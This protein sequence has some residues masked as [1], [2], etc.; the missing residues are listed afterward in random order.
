M[1]KR[2][3]IKNISLAGM[4]VTSLS[5]PLTLN[6]TGHLKSAGASYNEGDFWLRIREDYILK[7]EYINLENGYYNIIPQPTLKKYLEHIAHVNKEGAFYMR[8][9]Q[10]ENKAR[11]NARLA[12]FV[13]CA[14]TELILTRNTTESLDLI[15]SGYPWQEGDEAIMAHQDYGAML[16]MFKQVSKRAGMVNKLV[17]I[18][19]DPISDEELVALYE[20]QITS[21]TKLLMICHMVNITGH[22][23]PVCKICD[24]AHTH[25]VEVMVDGAHCI[26]HINVNI[27]ELHCDYYGSSLHKWVAAPLGVGMLYI[28]KNKISK[29]WPLFAE[30]IT[31]Q[32]N[33]LR[34]NH[35]GT[36][37]VHTHLAIAD[38]LDY[39]ELI[40]IERKEERLRHLQRYW[41]EQLR[42]VESIKIFTPTQVHRSC[43]IANV[44]VIGIPATELAKIL[45]EEYSVFTVGIDNAGVNGCRITPNVY[46][47]TVELDHFVASMKSIA[48]G[49]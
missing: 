48:A 29:L 34:L 27:E 16:N 26:G 46:T 42:E 3:F 2:D 35:T 22:I 43:A 47:T 8:G 31:E 36:H 10:E 11:I 9:V 6:A 40:G 17:D 41:S 12:K 14:E 33:I 5:F 44:G 4:A 20:S 1:K 13:G 19:Q 18:P 45:L 30:S 49:V 32:D 15:I 37:P 24:M 25:G 38:A 21:R 28:N 7:P 23:L 39:L